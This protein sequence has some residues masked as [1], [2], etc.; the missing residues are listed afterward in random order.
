VG[1][2]RCFPPATPE[3]EYSISATVDAV[4]AERVGIRLSPGAGIWDAHEDNVPKLYG[5]LL[6]E[7]DRLGLAYAHLEVTTDEETMVSLRRTWTGTMM[8]NPS[9]WTQRDG[10]PY[11]PVPTNRESADYWLAFGADLISFGRAFIANPD[12]VER[13]R[14]GLPLA[15][16]D[17]ATFYGGG[18]VGYLD[19]PRYR[20]AS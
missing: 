5:A 10:D 16:A 6:A 17:P 9:S 14:L 8:L 4:G 15:D 7:L 12:L 11:G 13:L 18:A 20:F 1:H 19:H 2:S 3:T